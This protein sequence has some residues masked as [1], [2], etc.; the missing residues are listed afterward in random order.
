MNIA[1]QQRRFADWLRDHGAIVHHVVNGFASGD[2]RNDLLQEVLL[3]IWKSIPAFR[4]EAK[5]TTYLYR[6]SHNAAL[7]WSRTE[8]NYRRRVERFTTSSTEVLTAD[9]DP[10]TDERLGKIYAAIHQLK[11]LDRSLMLLSLDGLSYRE[12]ADV[13]GL[14]ESN[15][16][17]KLNRIKAQLTETLKGN[18]HEP[19]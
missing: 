12:M 19:E 2:D 6:V 9:A 18:E 7:L 10:L 1:E 14:S 8:K 11:P 17:V 4:G 3:A 13:L 15:V 5:P 16:G